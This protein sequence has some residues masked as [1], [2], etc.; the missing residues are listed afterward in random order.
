MP[1]KPKRKVKVLKSNVDVTEKATGL[2]GR[3]THWLMDTDHTIKY[4]FQPRGLNPK[5]GE[6]ISAKVVPP[7]RLQASKKDYEKVEV[8]V[9]ILGTQIRDDASGFTGMAVEFIH[10][11]NGCFH[12]RIQPK[13]VIEETRSPIKS[14]DFD[15]RQCSG[16]AIQKMTEEE[17]RDSK[18]K[19]P[20]PAR[21]DFSEDIPTGSID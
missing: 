10:H 15:L 14:L 11:P 2:I 8:P 18:E 6:P 13:D 5:N 20:S 3:C 1:K 7:S 12:V 17:L 19:K 4:L 21:A 16:E 9:K